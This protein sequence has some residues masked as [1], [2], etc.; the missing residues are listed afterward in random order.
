MLTNKK[1]TILALSLV[2]IAFTAV[3]IKTNTIKPDAE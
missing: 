3:I 1:E 2:A